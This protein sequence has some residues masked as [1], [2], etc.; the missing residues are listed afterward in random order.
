[1]FL[2]KQFVRY[3]TITGWLCKPEKGVC[4]YVL[5]SGNQTRGFENCRFYN[6]FRASLQIYKKIMKISTSTTNY[7]FLQSTNKYIQKQWWL[8]FTLLGGSWKLKK[9]NFTCFALP[10]ILKEFTYKSTPFFQPTIYNRTDQNDDLQNY[11][12]SQQIL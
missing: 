4:L 5:D 2:R 3:N 9:Q 10:I 7:A 1:M 11:K 8:C 6:F 12:F